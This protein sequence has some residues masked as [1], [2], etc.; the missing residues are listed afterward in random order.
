[1][2]IFVEQDFIMNKELLSRITVK[3]EVCN[4]KPTLRGYRVT[5]QTI[6]EYLLSG[7]S[8]E[9]ILKQYPFL[10]QEDIQASKEF[11]LLLLDGRFSINGFAA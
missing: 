8:E 6:L 1:M 11:A 10:E 4:G 3:D 7:D 9:D 2:F 5:V